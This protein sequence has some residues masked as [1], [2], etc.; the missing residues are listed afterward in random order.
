LQKIQP[1]TLGEIRKLYVDTLSEIYERSEATTIA[2]F[3]F[4]EVMQ[5]NSLYQSLQTHLIL[6]V[7][8]ERVLLEYLARLKKK[9]P[10]QHVLGFRTVL[11]L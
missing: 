8:Q 4:E 7:E 6:T 11:R 5:L 2:R 1:L 9:E 10:F 3:M